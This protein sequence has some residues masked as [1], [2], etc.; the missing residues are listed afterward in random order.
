MILDIFSHLVGNK[1]YMTKKLVNTDDPGLCFLP[2]Q[3]FRE[4]I[5]RTIILCNSEAQRGFLFPNKGICFYQPG[6]SQHCR[7][8]FPTITHHSVSSLPLLPLL[9]YT[10]F[11]LYNSHTN[12][13][14]KLFE[15]LLGNSWLAWI[16]IV[17]SHTSARHVTDRTLS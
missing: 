3:L 8:S 13:V 17:P 2:L 14:L 9:C 15:T 11:N 12:G 4:P 6:S 16:F 5:T 1:F 7:S 10:P